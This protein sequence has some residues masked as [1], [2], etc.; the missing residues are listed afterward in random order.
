VTRRRPS[1]VSPAPSLRAEQVWLI[2]AITGSAADAERPECFVTP[3]PRM[4]AAARLGV[5]RGAYRARLVE[6][7]RDDYPVLAMTLGDAP[8]EA[9]AHTYIAR[10]P[11]SSPN[12]N[13]FGRHMPALCREVEPL[14]SAPHATLLAELAALEWAVVEVLHAEA[15]PALDVHE[16]QSSPPDRWA[17]AT[18]RSSAAVRLL[19][20]EHA[21]GPFYQ[22]CL[23]RGTAGNAPEARPAVTLVYRRDTKLWRM[24][25]TPLMHAVLAPLL[26]GESIGDALTGLEAS[27]SSPEDARELGE[28]L[29]VWFREWADAGLFA[30]V[31]LPPA[32]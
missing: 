12:L 18:F 5:Y 13:A 22:E 19:R 2:S 27:L 25:L 21:V 20:F 29:H 30:R 7:L 24:E 3:G 10:Y 23:E 26:A 15:S 1:A 28:K 16:L 17:S 11:S 32:T 8:F 9:L 14:R 6:C 31:D 4:D